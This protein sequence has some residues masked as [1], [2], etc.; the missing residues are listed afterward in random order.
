MGAANFDAYEGKVDVVIT[1]E[2]STKLKSI[3]SDQY[4]LGT[5]SHINA[6]NAFLDK[7]LEDVDYKKWF[8]GYFHI[9]KQITAKIHAVYEDII[10][11]EL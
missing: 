9:D 2:P 10:K 11:L 6:L 4:K 3:L 1:Y 8:F 5:M 7:L